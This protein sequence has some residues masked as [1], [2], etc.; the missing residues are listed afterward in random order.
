MKKIDS[1]KDWSFEELDDAYLAIQK[2]AEEKFGLD[3]YPNQ[4]EI[5]TSEQMLDAYSS[6]GMPIYYTHWSFGKQFVSESERYKRGQMGLAYEIVI[7]S[8]P[9]IA[10][11]MEENTM[12]M[13]CLV[14]AHAC[15][16]HNAF[17]KGN[18]H[19]KQWTDATSIV[20]YLSF[21]KHYIRECEE[22]YGA[23]EVE[24]ILDAA[25]SLSMHGVDKY[26]RPAKLSKEQAKERKKFLE[27]YNEEQQNDL[28]RT[29]PGND[30]TAVIKEEEQFPKEP[31]ENLLY[32][33]EKNA[34]NLDQWKREIV[35][36]VRKTAQYFYPQMLTKIG[37][38]GFATF[39]HYEIL[40]EMYEQG[41]V[42]DGFML[43]FL[44]S[45]TNVVMQRPMEPLNPYAIGFAMYQ[46]IKRIS[47]EPTEED[48]RWFPDW[49]GNSKWLENVKFAA[50]NFKDESFILQYLS[51]K[52][53]R[54]FKL[55][56]VLDDDEEEDMVVN[57]IHNDE[58]Y[59]VIRE[60]LSE[61]HNVNNRIPNIQVVRVDQWGDRSMHLVH[62]QTNRHCLDVKAT[63]KTLEHLLTLWEYPISLVSTDQQEPMSVK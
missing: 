10:Y 41:L 31:Q 13:Q 30:K 28:W 25:H 51:P 9:S 17:F 15:F 36:I 5:I 1:C 29:V 27:R 50:F 47:M 14:M 49:A 24:A 34:P 40:N 11:L 12:M 2:I 26:K 60:K 7:N 44:S 38:E 6:V 53:I 18:V 32:F 22:K 4:V 48:L 43:E 58:G 39:F 37:N 56:Y 8:S 54:D 19:F 46:D 57:S 35:R 42:T 61:Q 59:K 33:V 20:D 3:Y 55:F 63:Q 52:V 21:A 16:G 45:H 62:Y 23:D